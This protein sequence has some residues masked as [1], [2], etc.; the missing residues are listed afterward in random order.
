MAAALAECNPTFLGIFMASTQ[1]IAVTAL[2]LRGLLANAC[3]KEQF[4]GAEFRLY[5]TKDFQT[6][7]QLNSG[8]SIYLHRITFNTTRRNLPPRQDADGKRYR[9]PTPV[10]LH[11]LI[12]AW[13]RSAEEQQGLLGWVI[14]TLE[15]TPVLPAG[16]LNRF[17]GTRGE[18]FRSNETVEIVGDILSIQDMFN[19]WE[20]AKHNHQASISYIAR[21]IHLDSEIALTEAGPVQTRIF[22][23]TQATVQ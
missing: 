1:A 6:P 20:I 8:I 3:P 17:A 18:V 2:A 13:G 15:D 9:P 12:T 16:L 14:R 23:Y 19:L 21:M 10:D 22:D 11:Y 7:Q 5:Q 4:P